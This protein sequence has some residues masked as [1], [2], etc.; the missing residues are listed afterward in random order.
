MLA[1][2]T[3]TLLRVEAAYEDITNIHRPKS[4]LAFVLREANLQSLPLTVRPPDHQWRGTVEDDALRPVSMR[5]LA[6][7]LHIPVQ[8]C[9]ESLESLL[10]NGLIR[11][12]LAGYVID[13]TER[14]TARF[15][16]ADRRSYRVLFDFLSEGWVN[17]EWSDIIG[18]MPAPTPDLPAWQ[19]HM[20][21]R[22]WLRWVCRIFEFY[23]PIF[24]DPQAI[25]ATLALQRQSV[26]EG[27]QT[28]EG[29]GSGP[30][31]SSLAVAQ[32]TTM[33]R[34]TV[35]RRLH[36]L[37]ARRLVSKGKGGWRFT[38]PAREDSP[39]SLDKLKP[40]LI[41]FVRLAAELR[42]VAGALKE[43]TAPSVVAPG[44]V[45]LRR[46]TS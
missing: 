39:L 41:S 16:Q 9:H 20:C 11:K 31:V 23:I 44:D 26:F 3:R 13:Y 38:L 28:S 10:E 33:P 18:G 36:D 22:P 8:T 21:L 35:W 2:L 7:S 46:T 45:H 4:F 19:V 37:A 42:A 6:E 15:E 1:R 29:D 14:T 24:G 34:E 5:S 25:A 27:A 30:R 17:E 12:T 43:P 32:L 40:F